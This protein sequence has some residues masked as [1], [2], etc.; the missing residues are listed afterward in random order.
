MDVFKKHYNNKD[1]NYGIN[2]VRK[3][4]IFELLGRVEGKKVLDIGCATGYLGKEI[5]ERG[6]REVCG[7]DISENVINEARKNIDEAFA[8]DIQKDELPFVDNYF[9]SVILAEVIE[10]L[11]L[12]EIAM[13]KIKK[14]LKKDG[15]LIITT[16]NFLVFSNR[17]KMLLGKF[18]YT[19]SGFLDRGHIHFFTYDSLIEFIKKMGFK[20]EEENHM[21]HPKIPNFI[22]KLFPNLFTY[23][24]IIKLN[25]VLK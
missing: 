20:I 5:K 22:G 10:H 2:S 4:K 16:P 7:I 24:I 3:R 21:V 25:Q 18:K 14:I 19:E 12:P 17:I 9:D 15:S 11:F 6:A 13:E 1:I 8:L 23:Q